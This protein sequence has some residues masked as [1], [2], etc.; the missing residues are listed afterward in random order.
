[1]LVPLC[2]LPLSFL[3]LPS[4]LPR[5]CGKHYRTEDIV[6]RA[7]SYEVIS[8]NMLSS[9]KSQKGLRSEDSSDMNGTCEFHPQVNMDLVLGPLPLL[10]MPLSSV[11]SEIT[12]LFSRSR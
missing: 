10:G 4:I 7:S 11:R 3:S 5:T 12:F 2:S 9:A 6:P 1:M 8:G